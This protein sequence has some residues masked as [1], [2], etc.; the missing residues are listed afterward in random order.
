MQNDV[1]IVQTLIRAINRKRRRNQVGHSETNITM[2]INV[3]TLFRITIKTCRVVNVYV[4]KTY[5]M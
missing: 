1:T 4:S 2:N 5:K 3:M